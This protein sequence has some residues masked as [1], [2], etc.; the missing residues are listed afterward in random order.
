MLVYT[1]N[2]IGDYNTH[3]NNKN[4]HKLTRFSCLL[5][6]FME[7]HILD[8]NNNI[9]IRFF[10][11]YMVCWTYSFIVHQKNLNY[12][13]FLTSPCKDE[14]S[15]ALF[16]NSSQP[17]LLALRLSIELS[18]EFAAKSAKV[19]ETHKHRERE[20]E[21]ERERAVCVSYRMESGL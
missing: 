11:T 21:R 12:L 19:K 9:Q 15:M 5:R 20:R 8:T 16:W 13:S 14:S 6:I 17:C 1:Y 10:P 2:I 4:L 3:K 18:L 7:S